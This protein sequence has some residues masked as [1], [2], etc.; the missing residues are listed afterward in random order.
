MWCSTA[1]SRPFLCVNSSVNTQENGLYTLVPGKNRTRAPCLGIKCEHGLAVLSKSLLLL[2]T[3]LQDLLLIFQTGQE[4]TREKST[5]SHWKIYRRPIW[6]WFMPYFIPERYPRVKDIIVWFKK[7][8]LKQPLKV[9]GQLQ[10][11]AFSLEHPKWDK[12]EWLTPLSK[13]T[14][15]LCVFIHMGSHLRFWVLEV[16]VIV[17]KDQIWKPDWL[18]KQ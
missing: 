6:A 10:L 11:L 8:L 17:M 18:W 14:G 7:I 15:I 16:R 1:R 5:N 13:A 12:N 3:V 2:W 9:T 4:L